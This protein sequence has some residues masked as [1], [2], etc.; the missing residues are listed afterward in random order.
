MFTFSE[1]NSPT[2]TYTKVSGQFSGYGSQTQWF[3]EDVYA[4][5]F[6]DALAEIHLDTLSAWNFKGFSQNVYKKHN[7]I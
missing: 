2:K 5:K 4:S 3:S 1:D 6:I 7:K